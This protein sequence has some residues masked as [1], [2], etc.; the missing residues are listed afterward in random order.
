MA[1][2]KI[3]RKWCKAVKKSPRRLFF[4]N[5]AGYRYDTDMIDT[6]CLYYFYWTKTVCPTD[7]VAIVDRRSATS[8][9]LYGGVLRAF[10][11]PNAPWRQDGPDTSQPHNA[12]RLISVN[13]LSLTVIHL[14]RLDLFLNRCIGVAAFLLFVEPTV[15]SLYI[16]NNKQQY[17]ELCIYWCIVYYWCLYC[18]IPTRRTCMQD[19]SCSLRPVSGLVNL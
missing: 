7:N 11:S 10:M 8:S 4:W 6:T 12:P 5:L 14:V 9:C 13:I 18:E 2:C 16:Y 17:S 15:F 19:P 1:A 3:I